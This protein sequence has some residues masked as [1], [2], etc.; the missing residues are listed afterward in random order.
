MHGSRH[1]KRI[2]MDERLECASDQKGSDKLVSAFEFTSKCVGH[3]ISK[4][5]LSRM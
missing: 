2:D 1:H 5:A 4:Q 3:A